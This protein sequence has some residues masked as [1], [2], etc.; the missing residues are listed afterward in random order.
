MK[1]SCF[2][3]VVVAFIFILAATSVISAQDSL[4][5]DFN[6]IHAAYQSLQ[7]GMV[8]PTYKSLMKTT[9]DVFGQLVELPSVRGLSWHKFAE[10]EQRS[11]ASLNPETSLALPDLRKL[12]EFPKAV[13]V[14]RGKNF[15]IAR[16][17]TWKNHKDYG[18]YTRPVRIVNL[19]LFGLVYEANGCKYV[20]F[21]WTAE[22]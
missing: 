15:E 6:Q 3:P 11:L 21:T 16:L 22:K 5:C 20:W 9:I 8:W 12:F 17:D 4:R 7:K 14:I 13:T 18:D 2:S 19:D 10:K 1:K